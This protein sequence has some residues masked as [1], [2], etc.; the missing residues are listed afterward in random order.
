MIE[1]PSSRNDWRLD[2]VSILAI[3]G[4]SNIRLNSH[5]I[6][7][8]PTC[9]LPRLLPAPQALIG[10]ERARQLPSDDDAMVVG[11]FSLTKQASLNFFPNLLHGTGARLPPFSVREFNLEANKTDER[12]YAR[13]TLGLDQIVIEYRQF[14]TMSI[15]AIFSALISLGLMIWSILI[16]DGIGFIGI[17][18]M[19]FSSTLICMGYWWAP[20]LPKIRKPTGPDNRPPG[21]VVVRSRTGTFTIVHCDE[22]TARSLYFNP[23]ERKYHFQSSFLLS[24]RVF[25]AI[26]GG[27]F[28]TTAIV[29][30]GNCTWPLQVGLAAAY[31]ILNMSYWV[32][33]VLPAEWSW[34]LSGLRLEETDR[35]SVQCSSYTEA[36]WLAI[37]FSRSTKWVFPSQAVGETD[38]WKEW[39]RQADEAIHGSEEHQGNWKAVNELERLLDANAEKT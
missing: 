15:L 13:R 8:S 10:E 17:I 5:L 6:S 32:A 27:L 2:I 16:R 18:T 1:I 12:K 20:D 37:Q 33:T 38:V 29:F 7:A 23:T 26:F 28:L 11:S 9:L 39:L 3:L 21:D 30:F 24:R 35:C 34:D 31:T 4:E 25:G 36:L 19:S 22:N 14:G